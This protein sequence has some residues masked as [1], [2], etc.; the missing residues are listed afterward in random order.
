VSREKEAESIRAVRSAAQLNDTNR[1][2][3][4]VAT[5]A[6]GRHLAP[7]EQLACRNPAV[8]DD[9]LAPRVDQHRHIEPEGLD[10]GRDLADLPGGVEPRIVRVQL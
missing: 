7:P 5:E 10:A 1:V 2:G 4:R 9:H 6:D 8:P 3:Y